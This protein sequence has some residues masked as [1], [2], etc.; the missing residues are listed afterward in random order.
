MWRGSLSR[1]WSVYQQHALPLS[2]ASAL[3]NGGKYTYEQQ[4]TPPMVGFLNKLKTAHNSDVGVRFIG[5][6]PRL[7]KSSPYGVGGTLHLPTRN[8]L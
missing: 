1:A 2:T 8:P 5:P 7:D 6:T 4:E 3:H